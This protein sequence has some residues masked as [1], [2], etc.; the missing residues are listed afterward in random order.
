VGLSR[1]RPPAS[2]SHTG[3]GETSESERSQIHFRQSGWATSF[4]RGILCH[5]AHEEAA[6]VSFYQLPCEVYGPG[7][8]GFNRVQML[9]SRMLGIPLPL[10]LRFFRGGVIWSTDPWVELTKR[11]FS[12][13]LSCAV[14]IALGTGWPQPDESGGHAR[15]TLPQNRTD[16][17]GEGS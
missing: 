7:G 9:F 12:P 4:E 5:V 6:E 17:D 14:P 15:S 1:A 2:R 8:S 13:P 11:P 16:T 3:D 10:A